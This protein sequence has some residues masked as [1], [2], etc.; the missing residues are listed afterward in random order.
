[1]DV[2]GY[3]YNKFH[4]EALTAERAEDLSQFKKMNL[5]KKTMGERIVTPMHC[6]AINPNVEILRAFIDL[7][8]EVGVPDEKQRKLVHYAAACEG[9]GPLKMLVEEKMVDSR[10]AD[11][12]KNTTLMIACKY[13]NQKFFNF[14]IFIE[15]L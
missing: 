13:L 9:V 11:S 5:M 1:M 4:L 14:L 6:A 10:E 3:G 7:N 12:L 15:H 2:G 8:G